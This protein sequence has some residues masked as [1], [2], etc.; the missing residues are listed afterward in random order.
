MSWLGGR[1]D[2]LVVIVPRE[3]EEQLLKD[4]VVGGVRL[5]CILLLTNPVIFTQATG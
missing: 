4:M 3:G 1:T 2:H 5:D